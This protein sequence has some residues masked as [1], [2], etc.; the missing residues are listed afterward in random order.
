[1]IIL[2]HIRLKKWLYKKKMLNV[3]SWY[4]SI[5]FFLTAVEIDNLCITYVCLE[6]VRVRVSQKFLGSILN[7][8]LAIFSI[9]YL[10]E[11]N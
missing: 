6:W 11:K 7:I 8:S 5:L 10:L 1:L 9:I 3:I 2:G 4:Y